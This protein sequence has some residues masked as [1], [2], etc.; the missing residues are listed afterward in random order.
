MRHPWPDRTAELAEFGWRILPPSADGD[1]LDATRRFYLLIEDVMGKPNEQG[2]SVAQDVSFHVLNDLRLN[3]SAIQLGPLEAIGINAGIV[4]FLPHIFLLLL[5]LPLSG[6]ELEAWRSRA[7]SPLVRFLTVRGVV[8]DL[9]HLI[10]RFTTIMPRTES[11]RRYAGYLV[12]YAWKFLLFHELAH[13][14]RCHAIYVRDETIS[15]GLGAAPGDGSVIREIDD[16]ASDDVRRI[17]RLLE[18]DADRM[19]ARIQVGAHRFNTEDDL[20]ANYAETTGDVAENW[21]WQ[22]ECRTWLL[23][24]AL[25]FLVLTLLDG[26]TVPDKTR[27][28]PH[29]DVRFSFLGGHASEIWSELGVAASEYQSIARGVRNDMNALLWSEYLPSTVALTHPDYPTQYR[30][31]CQQ[32]A[33]SLLSATPRFNELAASRIARW[34]V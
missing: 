19:A 9:P 15:M 28:H 34:H 4:T 12:R 11:A 3:A 20:A 24:T 5:A 22:F 21:T 29:A 14:V 8:E 25:L 1:L 18:L 26:R 2:R 27:S 7:V 13:I 32:Y 6:P 30:L 31:E 10:P 33:A 23:A 17:Q 16:A